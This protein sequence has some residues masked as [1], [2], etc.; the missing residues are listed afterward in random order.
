M[1][2]AATSLWL[3][4][5]SSVDQ[6]LQEVW[7]VD[8]LLRKFSA[9]VRDFRGLVKLGKAVPGMAKFVVTAVRARPHAIASAH[10]AWTVAE[11]IEPYFF[12]LFAQLSGPS[13]EAGAS[14]SHEASLADMVGKPLASRLSYLQTLTQQ[15]HQRLGQPPVVG[16]H[17]ALRQRG[18]AIINDLTVPPEVRL[19]VHQGRLV[20]VLIVLVGSL[21][22][23]RRQ[24]KNTTRVRKLYLEA[25]RE[26]LD[27]KISFL[28]ALLQPSP[29]EPPPELSGE[30]PEP[31]PLEALDARWR[32]VRASFA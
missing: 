28:L 32:R 13:V 29:P 26:G 4:A 1:T 22:H 11:A 31:M 21:D 17:R 12:E 8:D 25:L 7:T 16:D 3:P 6:S 30:L 14:G 18:Q 2:A 10:E 19:L 5:V 15:L 9:I 23:A 24:G 20:P 27:L